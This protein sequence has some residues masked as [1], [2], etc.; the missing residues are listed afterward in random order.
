MFIEDC[1]CL[2]IL[3]FKLKPSWPLSGTHTPLNLGLY[4]STGL[5]K[6]FK[7][8][9]A[10]IYDRLIVQVASQPSAASASYA[11]FFY[12]CYNTFVPLKANKTINEVF[13]NI[14]GLQ[15]WWVHQPHILHPNPD[16]TSLDDHS[17]L[18]FM[19]SQT[20]AAYVSLQI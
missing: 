20:G 13:A 14:I 4:T 3:F 8:S 11:P 6:S 18:L 19:H 9:A 12:D 7:Q 2:D 1:L 17:C 10:A 15:E 16:Y 5:W